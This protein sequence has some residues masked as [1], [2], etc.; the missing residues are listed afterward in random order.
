MSTYRERRAARAERLRGWAETREQRAAEVFKAGEP[1]RGDTAFNTQP[2]HIPLRARVIA[3]EDRAHESLQK[4]RSMQSR[5]SGIE[6]QM[7]GSIYRDDPDAIPA[8]ERR[9]AGLEAERDRIKAYNASAR[10]GRPDTSLLDESQRASL[11]S[12][13]RYAPYQ[14]R[15]GA[16]PAYALT[17]L[18][19]NIKRNRDRLEQLR[20][21]AGN[22]RRKRP[23]AVKRSAPRGH[24]ATPHWHH[25][26][27]R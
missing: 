22:S 20:R 1:Y 5:A 9:I 27:G 26:G 17:N 2:G 4:A 25:H 15:G 13:Q 8:L 23:A 6:A 24:A 10:A 18:S 11:A 16:M 21:Q 12:V 19:G 14:S 7:A 3:R